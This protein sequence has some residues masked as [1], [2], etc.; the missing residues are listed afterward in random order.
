MWIIILVGAMIGIINSICVVIFEL[1]VFFE[2]YPTYE[3]QT[4]AQY[5]RIT[6]I[7]YLNIACILLLAEFNLNKKDLGFGLPLL[8]GKH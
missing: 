5:T 7:Q 3:Q 8:L 4:Q 2:K 6:I 1:I